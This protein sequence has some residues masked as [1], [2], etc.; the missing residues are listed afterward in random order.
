MILSILYSVEFCLVLI[1]MTIYQFSS[2]IYPQDSYNECEV[3]KLYF[4]H[5]G[6]S[7]D[8][9]NNVNRINS[10]DYITS[11]LLPTF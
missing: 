4:F 8:N 10:F 3:E 11:T 6:I 1:N 9:I 7:I 5:L 2:I